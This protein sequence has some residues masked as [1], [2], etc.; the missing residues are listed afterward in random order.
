MKKSTIAVTTVDTALLIASH[1]VIQKFL[2][3]SD[4]CHKTT[5]AATNA[6]INPIIIPIGFADNAAF[7][8][9]CATVNPL[10]LAAA[11]VYAV[12]ND[13]IKDVIPKATLNAINAAVPASTIGIIVSKFSP[14]VLMTSPTPSKDVPSNASPIFVIISENLSKII[15]LLSY[16][17]FASLVTN[18]IANSTIVDAASPAISNIIPILSEIAVI[19]PS[20]ISFPEVNNEGRMSSTN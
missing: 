9:H 11:A 17:A 4:L 12:T 14:S 16:I 5:N 6:T 18:S 2:K 7:N 1:I 20:T 15:S 13:C 10:E 19:K 8:A 3:D